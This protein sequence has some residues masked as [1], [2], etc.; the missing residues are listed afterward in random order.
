[1][2]PLTAKQ[3][4]IL[5]R[6]DNGDTLRWVDTPNPGAFWLDHKDTCSLT[7]MFRLFRDK[8]VLRANGTVTIT[9][10]GREALRVSRLKMAS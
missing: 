7:S 10:A 1:M 3:F 8:Y 6:L 5:S 9:D 2:H 4:L